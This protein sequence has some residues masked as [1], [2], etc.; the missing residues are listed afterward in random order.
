MGDWR[1]ESRDTK[2]VNRGQVTVQV[3]ARTGE[4]L[5]LWNPDVLE[6]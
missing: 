6:V 5:G 4:R 2:E 1:E 3:K